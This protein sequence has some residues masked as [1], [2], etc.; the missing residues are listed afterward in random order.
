MNE[1]LFNFRYFLLFSLTLFSINGFS[2]KNYDRL[3]EKD[4][5]VHPVT[6]KAEII[7]DGKDL[8]LYNGLVKRAFR[9][10]PNVAC[11]DYKNL[12]TGQ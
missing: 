11:Y 10:S 8:I 6:Q 2:Q 3:I 7:K 1:P 12:S 9:I 4:W 5:L